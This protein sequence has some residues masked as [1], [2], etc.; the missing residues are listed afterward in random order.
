VS[1]R[2]NVAIQETLAQQKRSPGLIF[3][4]SARRSSQFHDGEHAKTEQ[5]KL[6]EL[7]TQVFDTYSICSALLTTLSASRFFFDNRVESELITGN[8]AH[9]TVHLSFLLQ[10]I[11]LLI[12][13]V[14]TAAGLEAMMVFVL[15]TMYSKSALAVPNVGAKLFE[16]FMSKTGKQRYWAFGFM[17][18]SGVLS[19]FNLVIYCLSMPTFVVRYVV[20]AGLLDI[21]SVVS[22]FI[23]MIIAGVTMREISH[24]MG[25]ASII[26]VPIDKLD[27]YLEEESKPLLEE[28]QSEYLEE[29]SK[30]LLE[31]GQ[32]ESQ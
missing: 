28:G 15:C 11:H 22:A 29:E 4:M 26:F 16:Y 23:V 1:S 12:A 9:A 19:S 25:A 8:G 10:H 24:I 13:S 6:N 7:R 17:L 21:A 27:D 5:F 2:L 18:L 30:P 20:P 14:C 3:R 32:S 31:E